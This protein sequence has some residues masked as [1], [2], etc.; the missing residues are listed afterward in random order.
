MGKFFNEH[1]IS[2]IDGELH[3]T[4]KVCENTKHYS[5]Y[6]KNKN[7]CYG[8]VYTCKQC[9]VENGKSPNLV[10]ADDHY[11]QPAR[12]ILIKLGYDLNKSVPKQ[13]EER[14]G[15]WKSRQEKR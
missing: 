6:H 4:C 13:F 11:S 2:H 5:K 12:E 7:N 8:R 10:T 14:F 1:R 9:V 15:K 3:I